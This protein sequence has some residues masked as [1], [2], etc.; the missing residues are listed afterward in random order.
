[1]QEPIYEPK[2][3]QDILALVATFVEAAHQPPFPGVARFG[4]VARGLRLQ[5]RQDYHSEGVGVLFQPRS[6]LRGYNGCRVIQ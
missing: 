4:V 1:L 5:V 2:E 6:L 3:F